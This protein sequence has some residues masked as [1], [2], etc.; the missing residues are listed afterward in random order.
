MAVLPLVTAVGLAAMFTVGA[1]V[2]SPGIASEHPVTTASS[3]RLDNKITRRQRHGIQKERLF[4]F[5]S[6]FPLIRNDGLSKLCQM[7]DAKLSRNTI[8]V[9]SV[10]YLI[11]LIDKSFTN[12]N[13]KLAFKRRTAGIT[14]RLGRVC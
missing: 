9:S 13:L 14:I 6:S 1:G 10:L 2:G 8:P 5:M 3:D 4:I 12:H 11:D 7:L